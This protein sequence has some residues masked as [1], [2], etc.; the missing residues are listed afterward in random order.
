MLDVEGRGVE[1]AL[2]SSMAKVA[3]TSHISSARSPQTVMERVAAE[4]TGHF[5]SRPLLSAFFGYMDLH[6]NR[7]IFCT[8]G[9]PSPMVYRKK[10]NRIEVISVEEPS[11]GPCSGTWDERSLYLYP[12]DWLLLH[13]NGLPLLYGENEGEARQ[14]LCKELDGLLDTGSPADL[15]DRIGQ[16]YESRRGNGIPRDDIALIGVEILTQ[17]RRNLIKRELGF[18]LDDPVYLQFIRYFEEMDKSIGIILKAMDNQGF[19]DDTI[20][21]MKITLTELVVNALYHGNSKDPGR[22]VTLGHIVDKNRAVISIMDE[23]EGFDPSQVPDPTLPENLI[24]DS[25]RGL[26]IVRCYVDE[27]R[28]NAKGNRV[29]VT[30]YFGR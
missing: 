16:R 10:E 13:T 24:K 21:K 9:S 1:A 18:E 27:I 28:F 26:Y 25:G 2:L 11:I 12:G 7:L 15:V 29:T 4:L 23:G 17:S 14:G 8:A 3:F 22:K 30:K 20:R 6:S 5:P 19:A